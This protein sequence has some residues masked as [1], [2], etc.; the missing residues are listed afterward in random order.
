MAAQR[1]SNRELVSF[2]GN[3]EFLIKDPVLFPE[4]HRASPQ[5]LYMVFNDLQE[6]ISMDYKK[7]LILCNKCICCLRRNPCIAVWNE[8]LAKL[9]LAEGRIHVANLEHDINDWWDIY[10]L[11]KRLPASSS[12]VWYPALDVGWDPNA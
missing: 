1:L 5:G 9:I 10:I 4:L 2:L 11:P 7:L 3:Y 6:I 12:S 8:A